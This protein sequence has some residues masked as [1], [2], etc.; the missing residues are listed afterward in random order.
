MRDADLRVCEELLRKGS[1]SFSAAARLLPADVR[2]R[3]TVLYAFCRVADDLVDENP[4][5]SLQTVAELRERLARVYAGTP[6]DSPVDR[7]LAEVVAETRIPRAVPE[8]LLQGME[9][10]A[11]GHRYESLEDLEAYAARVAGTVGVMM[12]LAMGVRDPEALARAC[13]LGVAMQL[14]NVARDIGEDARN[15]RVYV[16]AAWLGETR[17]DRFS[18]ALAAV[19]RRLLERADVLYRRA[20]H[21]VPMLPPSCRVAIRAARLIYSD[22]GRVIAAN[23]YD[24]VTQR[25]ST[26][27]RRKL[28]LLGRATRARF[29]KRSV[30]GAPPLDATRDLVSACA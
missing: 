13:D 4:N 29:R 9:W 25:A 10:D 11:S 22:I 17:V 24:S 14:T 5:A 12:T 15:G 20:D 8:L 7:A 26:S 2:R 27:T 23:G 19:V 21:G 18:P 6:D 16:P 1:K 30:L 3:A 28:W